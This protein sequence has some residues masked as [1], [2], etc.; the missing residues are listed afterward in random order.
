MLYK[1][2]TVIGTTIRKRPLEGKIALGQVLARNIS[3]LVAKGAYKPIIDR[4]L[5]LDKVSE[6]MDV[7][8]SNTTFGKIILTT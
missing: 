7:M 6:A 4:V 5:S 1:R 2:L 3:P 8:S